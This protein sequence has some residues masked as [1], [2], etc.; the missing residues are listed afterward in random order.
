MVVTCGN[1]NHKPRKDQQQPFLKSSLN[2][3][4]ISANIPQRPTVGRSERLEILS[5]LYLF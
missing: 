5:E 2:L 1:F 3:K 4:S